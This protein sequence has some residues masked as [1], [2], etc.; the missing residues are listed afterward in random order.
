MREAPSSLDTTGDDEDPAGCPPESG[1]TSRDIAGGE[2]LS[3]PIAI[4]ADT[5]VARVNALT[6]TLVSRLLH[7][8]RRALSTETVYL[9]W[10]LHD[11]R[12]LVRKGV[13]RHLACRGRI[14]IETRRHTLAIVPDDSRLATPDA[15]VRT[16]PGHDLPDLERAR[17]ALWFEVLGRER[18]GND[19]EVSLTATA[20][21][22]VP[23]HVVYVRGRQIEAVAV[24][25]T[26]GRPDLAIR[27]ALVAALIDARRRG[28]T[29]TDSPGHGYATFPA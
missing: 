25:A 4:D 24:D 26:T 10:W 1:R 12:V 15:S 6:G 2:V 20:R 21:L 5:A 13:D 23:Y 17:R 18:R 27:D 3:L 22:L 11:Y 28:E 29:D 9:P 14:A 7:G 16:L 8:R 19:I